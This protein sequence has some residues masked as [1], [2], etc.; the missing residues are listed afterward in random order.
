MQRQVTPVLSTSSFQANESN[1]KNPKKWSSQRSHSKK[2]IRSQLRKLTTTDLLRGMRSRKCLSGKGSP[3]RWRFLDS[4]EC[5]GSKMSLTWD[6]PWIKHWKSKSL[7]LRRSREKART[8]TECSFNTLTSKVI[9]WRLKRPIDKC[10]GSSTEECQAIIN[11]RRWQSRSK[12]NNSK[13]LSVILLDHWEV[14]LVHLPW[15]PSDQ[16]H[17]KDLK[18]D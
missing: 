2:K 15:E 4:A 5:L 1:S 11:E 14:L 10:V 18:S 16:S 12:P 3:M 17:K 7:G 13:W 8:K 6:V 9:S